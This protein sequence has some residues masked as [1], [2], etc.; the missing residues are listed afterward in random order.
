MGTAI[1]NHVVWALERYSFML[2]ITWAATEAITAIRRIATRKLG[3]MTIVGFQFAERNWVTLRICS[4]LCKLCQVGHAHYS[5]LN[6]IGIDS[7]FLVSISFPQKY[8]IDRTIAIILWSVGNCKCCL[9]VNWLNNEIQ[10][11]LVILLIYQYIYLSMV[12]I[13]LIKKLI[14]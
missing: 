14:N 8:V 6:L 4:Y 12:C 9:R 13:L 2:S 1:Q 5:Y 3:I 10:A 7:L 11:K